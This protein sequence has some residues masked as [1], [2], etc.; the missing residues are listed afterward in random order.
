MR[1]VPVAVYVLPKEGDL[2]DPRVRQVLDLGEDGG[3]RSRSLAAAGEGD[4]AVAT[5]VVAAALDR[6]AMDCVGTRER[7]LAVN[8]TRNP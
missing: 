5:H 4:D 8:L 3:H 1:C 2:P 7:I 6:T